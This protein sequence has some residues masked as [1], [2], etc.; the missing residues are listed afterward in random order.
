MSKYAFAETPADVE[1][2]LNYALRLLMYIP[3]SYM[4]KPAAA[5]VREI[6]GQELRARD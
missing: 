1:V 4:P 5:K 3:A 2:F 6:W